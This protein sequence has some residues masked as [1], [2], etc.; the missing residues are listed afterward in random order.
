MKRNHEPYS[1]DNQGLCIAIFSR[2]SNRLILNEAELSVHLSTFFKLPICWIRL[3]DHPL[4]KLIA[5]LR[6]AVAAF[7]MHGSILVLAMFMPPGSVLVEGFPYGVPPENYTPYKTMVELPGQRMAYRAWAPHDPAD[8]IGYPDRPK[9]EGGLGHLEEEQ[10]QFIMTEP[11]IPPHK[12]CDNPHW[13]YRIFQDTRVDPVAIELL[14][15]DA[16]VEV[17]ASIDFASG[18]YK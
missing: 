10:R 17:Q 16:L 13:L 4:P 3:E 6:N 14:I 9:W 11:T 1:A 18:E 2:R 12:C 7:G 15:R 8:S 5:R